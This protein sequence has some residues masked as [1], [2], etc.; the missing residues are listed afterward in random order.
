MLTK[1]SAASGWWEDCNG[2]LTYWLQVNRH[3]D[4]RSFTQ[5]F[6]WNVR[7]FVPD[8]KGNGTTGDPRR[9]KY[10]SGFKG[11]MHS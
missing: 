8:T 3:I 5:A 4:G 6:I 1:L 11:R 2:Q 10:R 9:P 7:T